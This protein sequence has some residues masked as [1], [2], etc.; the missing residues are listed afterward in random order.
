M[1]PRQPRWQRGALPLS[2]SR[3]FVRLQGLS[4]Q[5]AFGVSDCRLVPFRSCRIES[6]GDYISLGSSFSSRLPK[7]PNSASPKARG[8]E[9]KPVKAV[10]KA[11]LMPRF[12]SPFSRLGEGIRAAPASAPFVARIADQARGARI[13]IIR[14]FSIEGVFSTLATSSSAWRTRFMTRRPSSI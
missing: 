12:A 3:P 6:V 2:Y 4:F 14:L 13:A 7:I 11:R 10:D 1:N 8:P 9:G 5:K